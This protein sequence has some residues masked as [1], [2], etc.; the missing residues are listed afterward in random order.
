MNDSCCF[1]LSSFIPSF[2]PPSFPP[3]LLPSFLSFFL[4]P[5]PASG[6][7]SEN[8]TLLSSGDELF[9]LANRGYSKWHIRF[10]L[11][12]LSF[13]SAIGEP[14]ASRRCFVCIC[15]SESNKPYVSFYRMHIVSRLRIILSHSFF[16]FIFYRR[17]LVWL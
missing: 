6:T 14:P 1:I 3:S 10:F 15:L 16:V 8:D 4:P 7:E 2:L 11:G 12:M 9:V 5:Y 13:F 17:F